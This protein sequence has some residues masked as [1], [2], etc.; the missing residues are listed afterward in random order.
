MITAAILFVCVLAFLLFLV[1]YCRSLTSSASFHAP[2]REVQDAAGIRKSP[3]ANDF[4]RVRQLLRLLPIQSK[5]A[6]SLRIVVFYYWILSFLESTVTHLSPSLGTWAEEERTS[7]ARFAL[8]V[9][10]RQIAL[11]S[12]AENH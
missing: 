2:S 10:D 3:T 8:L 5:T 9:L 1:A 11:E 7:C 12:R 4:V 6:R